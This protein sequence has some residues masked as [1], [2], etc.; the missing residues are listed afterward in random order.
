MARFLFFFCLW[1]VA[2]AG[3]FETAVW[4]A[5]F[6]PRTAA[7][8]SWSVSSRELVGWL[9]VRESEDRVWGKL[10]W[11]GAGA[12]RREAEIDLSGEDAEHLRREVEQ[13]LRGLGPSSLRLDRRADGQGQ[14]EVW[15]IRT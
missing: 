7:C 12:A 11:R 9:A 4:A 3:D 15:R 14:C 6:Q 5:R 10:I 13:M 1:L 2:Q 8:D